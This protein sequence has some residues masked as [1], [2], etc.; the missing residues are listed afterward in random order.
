M[1]IW[2]VVVLMHVSLC[3]SE[4]QIRLPDEEPLTS[5]ESRRGRNLLNLIGL[6][7]YAELDPYQLKLQSQCVNGEFSE[8]FKLQA[9][10]SL[11]DFFIRN[12]YE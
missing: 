7:S 10:N 12:N 6:G 1:N 8:C 5:N 2:I 3:S 4:N 9:V 11:G